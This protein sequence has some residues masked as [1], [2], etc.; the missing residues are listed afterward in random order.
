MPSLTV[1][2]SAAYGAVID[3]VVGPDQILRV[4]YLQAMLQPSQPAAIRMLVD[5][6]ADHTTVH[7]RALAGWI[8]TGGSF[9]TVN[10]N[11]G[12]SSRRRH[13]FAFSI[14]GAQG[15]PLISLDPLAMTITDSDAFDGA[16]FL[17]LIGRDVLNL[18]QFLY[19]GPASVCTL[20]F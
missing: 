18:G 15:K 19:D 8:L 17:G 16:P 9:I 13:D 2:R 1:P 12:R 11:A 6:G 14:L 4:A 10:T 5:T 20:T 7:E 3:V